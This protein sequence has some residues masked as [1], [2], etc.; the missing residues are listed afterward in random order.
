MKRFVWLM[1]LAVC[2]ACSP[3]ENSVSTAV[4]D[5]V[6]RGGRVVD[7][8]TGLD[9]IRNVGITDGRIAA[10]SEQPL[11]GTEVVDA[12]GLIVAPGFINLHSHAW[13]P[14]GQRFEVQDGVTTT[15]EL[16]S[17]SY[18]ASAFGT[19]EPIA[20]ANRSR[21][22]FGASLGHAWIRSAILEGENSVTGFEELVAGALNG[23]AGG[24]SMERPAF[25]QALDSNQKAELR[26]RLNSGLDA[27][28][29]GIGMLLDYMSEVVDS[30]EMQLVFEV[31]GERKAPIF[32]HIRRGV[33]GD[34]AGLIEVIELAKA[35]GAPVHICHIQANAMNN[36]VEF[37]QLVREANAAGAKVTME[38]FPYNAGSTAISA[39]VFNRDWQKIFAITYEDVEWLATGER[40]TE[41]LWN[42]YREEAPGGIVVHHYN[43][44]EWTRIASIAPDVIVAS[45]GQPV[46]N[47]QNK[48]IPFGI[49]TNSRIY[50]RYVREEGSLDLMTA[51]AKMTLLPAQVLEDYSEAFKRK[52]RI[53]IGAD[54]DLTIFDLESI[55]D[56][57]TYREPFLVST[58]I[59]HVIVS[60]KFALRNGKLL[61][62]SYPGKRILK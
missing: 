10:V 45:D 14:I 58:G 53:S 1:A 42:Q 62:D 41:E 33:A 46:I 40:L 54:A 2:A 55:Q 52:G 11:A 47:L 44:E 49:G 34:T 3:P 15:L 20:I 4:Y 12:A 13:T 19:Y 28:G 38:S 6:I 29:L 24:L 8:D 22:H 27:G 35:T 17:G 32:V 39:A 36:V 57:A 7:P 16:E 9:A 43:R 37:M 60:G 61:E 56:H 18:P 25:R 21:A 31:A 59:A 26:S 48:T 30:A 23:T 5:L 50:A 51:V